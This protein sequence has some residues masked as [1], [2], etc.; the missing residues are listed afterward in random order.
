MAEYPTTIRG[1]LEVLIVA[2][3]CGWL[4]LNLKGVTAPRIPRGTFELLRQGIWKDGLVV[5][6]EALAMPFPVTM[7]QISP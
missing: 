1:K 5:T 7:S 3:I 4:I 6:T 2:T